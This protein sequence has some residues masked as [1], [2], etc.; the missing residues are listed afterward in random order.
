MNNLKSKTKGDVGELMAAKFL[1]NEGCRILQRN[2]R[3]ERGEIDIVAEDNGEL[4][5][6][7]V[8]SRHTRS[9]GSPEEALTPEKE[10]Y[11]KRTAEGY[12]LEHG[13]ED[14][15]CRFD[16]IAIDWTGEQAEMRHIK[17]IF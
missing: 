8:K 1:E 10:F 6:V 17:T 13:L 9:H 12:L 11:L 15:M 3:Y 5:F 2:Y 16:L 14:R 4:V 7:E